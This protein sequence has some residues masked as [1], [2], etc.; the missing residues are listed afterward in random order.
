MKV[1]VICNSDQLGIPSVVR[2]KELGCLVGVSYLNRYSSLK[3]SFLASGIGDELLYP[4]ETKDWALS[5]EQT[6]SF[7]Q[8]DCVFVV[9]FPW[10]I[11]SKLLSLPQK[12]FIN[13]HFGILPKYK[14][15]DPV[16]W[17]LKN[18]EEA[19]GLTIHQM[20]D[21]LD[22]GAVI[23]QEKVPITGGESYGIYCHQ[24]AQASS[25]LIPQ[26]IEKLKT[27][28]VA[29]ITLK[30]EEAFNTGLPDEKDLAI[31]WIRQTAYEVECLVNA[32]NPRYG[33]AR[34][35]F[36]GQP[37]RIFEVTPMGGNE[38]MVGA[39]GEIVYADL[40]YGVIV[41]CADGEFVRIT[42]AQLGGAFIS[43]VKLSSFGFL[44]GAKF[45]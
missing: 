19:G 1:F 37:L 13:F 20:T 3:E 41:A 24:L 26:V 8:A 18:Q 11:P 34:T 9:T 43:G 23:W 29:Y 35:S 39:P 10:K 5:L 21:K 14:G 17:E 36:G 33:G 31:D 25:R 15:S 22:E 40:T 42:I 12:G 27:E 45:D 38:D 32:A 4:L 28:P 2:L 16:F 44:K 30:D 6:I 7:L